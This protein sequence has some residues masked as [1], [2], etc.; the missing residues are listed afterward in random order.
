MMTCESYA[1]A[2]KKGLTSTIRL[3][4]SKGLLLDDAEE[5]AQSAWVRGWE[6][7]EQLKHADLVVNWVNTIAIRKMC[8]EK[9]RANRHEELEDEQISTAAPMT[10]KIDAERLLQKCSTLD[11]SL[12][13]HRYA[14][15]FAME[16]IAKMHG[17][18]AVGARV[19]IHRAKS[20]LRR[21]A[22]SHTMEMAA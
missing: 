7:R 9:R 13:K 21:F 20:A 4:R 3:L 16:Q 15:G 8:T 2:Y 12:I 14:G 11:R 18:T 1:S 6:A 19:R 22:S 5:L 10:A 17:L